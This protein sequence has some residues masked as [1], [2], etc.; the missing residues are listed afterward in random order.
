MFESKSM[1]IDTHQHLGPCYIFDIEVTKE[2]LIKTMDGNEIEASI[3]QLFPGV[4]DY[5][6]QN[7][8]IIELCRELPK[9]FF[10]LIDINPHLPEKEFN[11]EADRLMKTSVFK[12]IKLH[13]IGHSISP[14]SND[15]NKVFNFARKNNI[16]VMVHTGPGI[17]FALPS[18]VIPKA[19]EYKDVNFILAHSGSA[20]IFSPEAYVAASI[21]DNIFLET[22]WTSIGDKSWFISAFGSERIM[23]GADVPINVSVELFQFKALDLNDKDI[24][25]IM[26]ETAKKVYKIEI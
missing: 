12:A 8:K 16:P 2:E 1:L 6:A 3:I 9:R 21:C 25:N 5:K 20:Q 24:K 19:K 18:L 17:P 4:S 11:Y 10:G 13:T 26:A 22:S 7:D 14:L 23:F 15:A